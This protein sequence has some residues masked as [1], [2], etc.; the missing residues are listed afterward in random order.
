MTLPVAGDTN[1]DGGKS[2]KLL[3]MVGKVVGKPQRS[4][5]VMGG[6]ASPDGTASIWKNSGV[7]RPS[8]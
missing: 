4:S 1:T 7:S 3:E 5:D 8:G 2:Y 6:H